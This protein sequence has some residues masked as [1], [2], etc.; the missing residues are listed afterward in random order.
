MTRSVTMCA[1]PAATPDLM[2][3][4]ECNDY[5]FVDFLR[6]LLQY[7]PSEFLQWHLWAI[8]L[9]FAST[10]RS[11]GAN[12]KMGEWKINIEYGMILWIRIHIL[13]STIL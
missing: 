11:N 13:Q 8:Q 7:N 12:M 4:L 5:A 9:Y 2:E 1:L 3:Q 10:F 6:L